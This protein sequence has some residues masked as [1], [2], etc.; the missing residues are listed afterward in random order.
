MT[1]HLACGNSLSPGD[2]AKSSPSGWYELLR[3]GRNLGRGDAAADK[4]PLPASAAHWRKISTPAGEEWVDLNATGIF[5]LSDADFPACAGW[6]CIADDAST[7]DQ[8]CDSVRLG[9]KP[10]TAL[11]PTIDGYSPSQPSSSR[12]FFSALVSKAWM[13]TLLSTAWPASLSGRARRAFCMASIWAGVNSRSTI[14]G[15]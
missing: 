8:R 4:D 6:T 14:S 2:K 1:V 11:N 5:K 3:F 12:S 15:K 9:T 10:P 7:E 13:P